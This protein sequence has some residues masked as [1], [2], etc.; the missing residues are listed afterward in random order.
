[1]TVLALPLAFLPLLARAKVLSS[2][3]VLPPNIIGV[4][5]SQSGRPIEGVEV[6]DIAT[7]MWTTTSRSGA[8]LLTFVEFRD[9]S[10]RIGLRKLGY[11]PTEL[12]LHEGASEPVLLDPV[13]SL[14]TVRTTAR[15]RLD[16]DPGDRA[17]FERR[18]Q[19]ASPNQDVRPISGLG[20]SRI[21]STSLKFGVGSTADTSIEMR[22]GDLLRLTIR[23]SG[24][25]SI[26]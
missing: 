21:V 5:D 19:Q 13:V 7:E 23:S 15:Y 2:A 3:V 12:V 24:P 20:I 1:L 26:L 25:T 14:P 6:H 9:S 11:R 22:S 8:A 17:G 18:C 4:Y 10:A 16:T